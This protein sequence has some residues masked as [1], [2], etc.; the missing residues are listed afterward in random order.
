MDRR[1]P[2]PTGK[3]GQARRGIR[4]WFPQG[5]IPQPVQGRGEVY[6]HREAVSRQEREQVL[7]RKLQVTWDA[8]DINVIRKVI[9]EL[10]SKSQIIEAT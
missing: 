6:H 7:F 10:G 9:Q 2:N 5:M 1:G 4:D 3:R 8:W